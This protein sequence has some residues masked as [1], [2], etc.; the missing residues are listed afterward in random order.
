MT[1]LS[2][3][4]TH[5]HHD[6]GGG[7]KSAKKKDGGGGEDEGSREG[8]RGGDVVDQGPGEEDE[9]SGENEAFE[10]SCELVCCVIA[11]THVGHRQMV[12][13]ASHHLTLHCVCWVPELP[14]AAPRDRHVWVSLDD[15]QR[16]FQ[17]LWKNT[18]GHL[19]TGRDV[20]RRRGGWEEGLV[21][22]VG[23]CVSFWQCEGFGPP[24]LGVVR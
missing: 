23:C 15:V 4:R 12:S 20:G 13:S 22:G 24:G 10:L 8:G 7:R 2:R 1:N 21:G 14:V 17:L 5:P 16:I 9:G 3:Q 6:D 19:G 18:R 11:F